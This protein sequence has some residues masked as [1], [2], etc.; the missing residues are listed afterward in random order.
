MCASQ[1][2]NR[3]HLLKQNHSHDASNTSFLVYLDESKATIRWHVKTCPAK[4]K[5]CEWAP[6]A[7]T[8][9]RPHGICFLWASLDLF[10]CCLLPACCPT[11]APW[12]DTRLPRSNAK[13]DPMFLFFRFGL[14]FG[15]IDMGQRWAMPQWPEG[16]I[17]FVSCLGDPRYRRTKR[18][19]RP[20]KKWLRTTG[21]NQRKVS[22]IGKY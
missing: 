13:H 11:W 18:V 17:F 15:L 3:I 14:R 6:K 19:E 8:G 1:C 12:H 4:M 21:F 16:W 2:I 5:G 10:A 20:R 7:S 9:C 22:K